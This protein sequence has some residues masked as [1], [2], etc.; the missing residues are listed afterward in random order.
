MRRFL[1]KNKN[2]FTLVEVIVVVTILAVMAAI[3]MPSLTGYID[4][5]REKQAINEANTM[6]VNLQAYISETYASVEVP[7]NEVEDDGMPKTIE[8]YIADHL[9]GDGV[10]SGE[11]DPTNEL[12]Q[13]YDEYMPEDI[14]YTVIPN[15]RLARISAGVLEGRAEQVKINSSGIVTF[16]KFKNSLNTYE[17]IYTFDGTKPQ[18]GAKK[19]P[20]A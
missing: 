8:R 7:P 13:F 9:F 12:N 3:F 6:L 17:I 14:R 11:S 18:F 5:V 16:F 2:G 19:L 1:H 10:P 4:T 20:V 15:S